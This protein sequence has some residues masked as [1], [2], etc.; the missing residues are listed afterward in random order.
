MVSEGK[1]KKKELFKWTCLL[2]AVCLCMAGCQIRAKKEDR[3]T[4]AERP[5]TGTQ[6]AEELTTAWKEETGQVVPEDALK[7]EGHFYKIY[8]ESLPWNEARRA[9]EEKGG[10]LVTVTSQGEQDFLVS[11]IE[12]SGTEKK[13][14]WLGASDEEEEGQWTWVTGESMDYTNWEFAKHVQPSNSRDTDSEHGE[15]YLELQMTRPEDDEE[16][17]TTWNDTTDEGTAYKYE[18]EPEYYSLRY[19]GYICEWEPDEAQESGNLSGSGKLAKPELT[20]SMSE[21]GKVLLEWKAVA[22]ASAYEISRYGSGGKWK[23]LGTTKELSYTD[24]DIRQGNT[25]RYRVRATGKAGGKQLVSDYAKDKIKVKIV[26]RALIVD[27]ETK[28]SKRM[29]RYLKKAGFLVDRVASLD[30]FNTDDYDTLVIP[31]GHNITPSVYGAERAPETYGTD[32]ELDQLQI[33]AVK[34]FVDKKKPVLG[35][36][37]GCQ[38]INVALGGTINQHIPGWHKKYRNVEI[39]ESSWLYPRLGASESV[40]HYHHQ[41]VENLADGLKATMWDEADGRIEGYE[42]ESLPVYGIQWHPDSMGNQGIDI[43]KYYRAFVEDYKKT[44]Q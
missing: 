4:Q 9:C 44:H 43:F 23:S 28:S 16:E 15:D 37:R 26:I 2:F 32:L 40:Y 41:C 34:R 6:A 36:C 18:G 24:P 30:D 25:Y 29:V 17:Y 5:E 7:Y 14:F 21:E 1:M 19:F 39:D 33:A 8:E 10:H 42:H 38:L 27:Y 22:N 11:M 20:I 12:E 31:G 3:R 35:V 13:H